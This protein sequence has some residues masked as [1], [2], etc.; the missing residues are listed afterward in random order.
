MDIITLLVGL[1]V[2]LVVIVAVGAGTP[3]LIKN[4]QG[5]PFEAQIETALTEYAV[6]AIAVGYRMSEKAI[7]E[8][9]HRLA[10]VDKKT[11]AYAIYDMLPPEIG[12]IPIAVVKAIVTKERFGQLVQNAF[13]QFDLFWGARQA[14]LEQLYSAW[15]NDNFP[16]H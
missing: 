4:R 15:I 3:W 5:Y 13:Y 6:T 14:Q 7:D 11:F 1:V 16:P 10:G 2:G 12:G 9:G 8:L